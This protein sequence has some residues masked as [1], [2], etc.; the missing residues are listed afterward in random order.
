MTASSS[1]PGMPQDLTAPDAAA[2]DTYHDPASAL[3]WALRLETVAWFPLILAILSF[4]VLVA[5][6]YTYLPQVIS[7]GVFEAYLSVSLPILIPLSSAIVGAALFVLLRA[8]S[9]AL[10][11]LLDLQEKPSGT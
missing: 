7:A 1:K 4:V 2:A 3:K 11:L 8:A 5:E 6:L 10:L 9:Q